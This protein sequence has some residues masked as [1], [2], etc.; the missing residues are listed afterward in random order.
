MWTLCTSA[1]NTDQC[2]T[3]ETKQNLFLWDP[4][5]F[6]QRK[7]DRLNRSWDERT[8]WK[9]KRK[10]PT[11]GSWHI[12]C[13]SAK[14]TEPPRKL[15]WA[16][17]DPYLRDTPQ[18]AWTQALCVPVCKMSY[19]ISNDPII[20]AFYCVQLLGCGLQYTSRWR[21]A[22]DTGV[23]I[24]RTQTGGHRA[25]RRHLPLSRRMVYDA[26]LT[27]TCGN[28]LWFVLCCSFPMGHLRTLGLMLQCA[29]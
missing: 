12:N 21:D 10:K 25:D 9:K 19:I 15:W 8:F 29:S 13:C 4:F 11:V 16:D 27:P 3:E 17:S 5:F 14:D 26:V 18:P 28:C 7:A 1:G 23:T 2:E 6:K 22:C 20:V 24:K